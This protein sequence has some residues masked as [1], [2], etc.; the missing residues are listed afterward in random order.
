VR[1]E[2]RTVNEKRV[3]PSIVCFMGTSVWVSGANLVHTEFGLEFVDR[4]SENACAVFAAVSLE[5]GKG[6]TKLSKF[7]E[8]G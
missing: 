6:R 7:G 1:D 4:V 5:N 3:R 2:R 8:S